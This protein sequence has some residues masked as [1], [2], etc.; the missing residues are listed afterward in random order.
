VDVVLPILEKFEPE[1]LI[2]SAGYDSHFSDYMSSLG[3]V[4]GSYQ[5]IMN[6]LSYISDKLCGGRMAIVLEGG[7]EHR[8]T[9]NSVASTIMGSLEYGEPKSIGDLEIIFGID[10]E[11][12]DNKVKNN[13]VL[14]QAAKNS[15][16]D[17]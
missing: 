7:Y 6:A 3:L 14:D 1:L 10:D 8:S 11:Y 15:R 17:R 5:K 4:E 16:I 9:A 13:M 12:R 2:I